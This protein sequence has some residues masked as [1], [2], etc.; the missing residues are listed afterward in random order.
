TC[1]H[2]GA[3]SHLRSPC[4][5]SLPPCIQNPNHICL[6]RTS[7]REIK[8]RCRSVSSTPVCT[9]MAHLVTL[10]SDHGWRILLQRTKKVLTLASSWTNSTANI[11]TSAFLSP[12]SVTYDVMLIKSTLNV[13]IFLYSY[14]SFH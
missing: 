12:K 10:L 4:V 13:H 6:M 14:F 1:L 11:P 3:F 5:S 8:S 9:S 7:G 2:H